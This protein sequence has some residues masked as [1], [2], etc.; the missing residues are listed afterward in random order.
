MEKT[1]KKALALRQC[2]AALAIMLCL[3]STSRAQITETPTGG[4]V[5]VHFYV[6][7]KSEGM[8]REPRV[9]YSI[10]GTSYGPISG[11]QINE[12]NMLGHK[13][14]HFTINAPYDNGNKCLQYPI[15]FRGGDISWKEGVISSRKSNH[16]Q[17]SFCGDTFMFI[18]DIPILNIRYDYITADPD[19]ETML[20][21][22]FDP[23]TKRSTMLDEPNK[24]GQI[25]W[26]VNTQDFRHV[27][28]QN[29]EMTSYPYSTE[30]VLVRKSAY[31]S[32]KYTN[33]N[34]F[35]EGELKMPFGSDADLRGNDVFHACANGGSD[36]TFN[37]LR[38]V[39]EKAWPEGCTATSSCRVE[40]DPTSTTNFG[41]VGHFR[42]TLTPK[43]KRWKAES[44][45][46]VENHHTDGWATFCAPYN[47]RLPKGM[48][49]LIATTL[50]TE[51]GEDHVIMVP[52]SDYPYIPANNGVVIKGTG[53]FQ[54][55]ALP[56]GTD[57]TNVNGVD[58][59]DEYANSGNRMKSV[60]LADVTNQSYLLPYSCGE[61]KHYV[62]TY[63]HGP[64]FVPATYETGSG[65]DDDLTDGGHIPPFKSYL[66]IG[67]VTHTRELNICWGGEADAINDV[68]VA[69]PQTTT[70]YNLA[71]RKMNSGKLPQGIY[72][73]N[74]KK[75]VVK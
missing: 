27:E 43:I 14:F 66:C 71:G 2:I 33:S 69:A 7:V 37:T 63:E 16:Q 3:P 19:A 49:V 47:V 21:Y 13:Y 52:M 75:R 61:G 39:S 34:G 55:M 12:V 9:Y 59:S 64:K 30:V 32:Y 45:V 4:K 1:R 8:E 6:R 53:T 24:K 70:V 15:V 5:A 56:E 58:I 23:T 67:G 46:Q 31:S 65:W 50:E 35:T 40:A 73:V 42:L 25:I 29:Y 41:L 10:N 38:E 36:I 26:E 18:D 28:N 11:S 60:A 44:W 22:K 74:G 62:L 20:M 72:I 68:P 48:I 57:I 54:F 17:A 51:N